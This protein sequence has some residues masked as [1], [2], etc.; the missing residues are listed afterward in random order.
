MPILSV[1]LKFVII[2]IYAPLRTRLYWYTDARPVWVG[3][4]G[5]PVFWTGG[6]VWPVN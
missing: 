2:N 3:D 6:A 1:Q 5:W 4:T